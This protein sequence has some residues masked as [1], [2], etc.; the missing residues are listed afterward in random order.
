M[1]RYRLNSPASALQ[2][3]APSG[4][5]HTSNPD[6]AAGAEARGSSS[7]VPESPSP[8]RGLPRNRSGPDGSSVHGGS[9]PSQS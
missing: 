4:S 9:M 7:I 8:R 2:R 3:K 5:T 1:P 6:G